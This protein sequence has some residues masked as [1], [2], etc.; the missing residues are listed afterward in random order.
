MLQQ[1]IEFKH[2]VDGESA[3]ASTD[4]RLTW[5]FARVPPAW[6]LNHLAVI[7]LYQSATAHLGTPVNRP[8][9]FQPERQLL[10]GIR[11][12]QQEIPVHGARQGRFD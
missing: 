2:L 4:S 1:F 12:H 11:N 9:C 3:S 7:L 6:L 10:R 5:T 8:G